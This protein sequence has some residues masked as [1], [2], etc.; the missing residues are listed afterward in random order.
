MRHTP[1]ADHPI[2]GTWRLLSCTEKNLETGAVSYPLGEKAAAIMIYTADGYAATIFT[3]ADRKA[4]AGAQATEQEAS[5]LYR[6][7]IAFAGRY[8]LIG[9]RLVYRP[10]LSWNEAWNGTTQE[11]VCEVH[12]DRLEVRSIPAVS[13]VTGATSVFSLL[14]ERARD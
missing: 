10:E 7:M 2:A 11:R 1:D 13:P 9:D 12:G 4:P 14:W 5:H 6:S 3:R 8:Q